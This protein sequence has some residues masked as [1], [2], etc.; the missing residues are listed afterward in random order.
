MLTDIAFAV[1]AHSLYGFIKFVILS[2]SKNMGQSDVSW[3]GAR[4]MLSMNCDEPLVEVAQRRTVRKIKE[5]IIVPYANLVEP[6]RR[7]RTD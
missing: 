4:I 6:H 3:P 7:Y 2:V 5:S 1:F